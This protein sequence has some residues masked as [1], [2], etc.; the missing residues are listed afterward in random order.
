M[1][2]AHSIK[3]VFD[4][5]PHFRIDPVTRNITNRSGKVV[6]VQH[7][8]NSERFTFEIPQYVDGHDM[9]L[10]NNVEIHYINGNST[11]KNPGL[12]K[13]DDLTLDEANKIVYCSWL[14]SH[15]ATKL[16][17]PLSFMVRFECLTGDVI[18]YAW[19]TG[20]HSGVTVS[21][22]IYNTDCVLEDYVDVLE[23]WRIELEEA[24]VTMTG[25]EQTVVSTEDKGIN[26]VT[27]N[28]SNGTTGTFTVQNGSR[29]PTGS[30]IQSITRTDGTGAA[31]TTDTY[32]ITLTDGKTSTFQVYNG[33]NGLNGE[34]AGDMIASTYDPNNIAKDIFAYAD[35]IQ[36]N[37][38]YH[39][40]DTDMHVTVDEK[41]K[42][43]NKQD[44]LT[45]D[46]VPTADSDNPVTSGGV[47]TSLQ[48]IETTIGDIGA[49]LDSI[50]GE[51]V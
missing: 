43:G 34:G 24:G 12:Y 47:Y 40:D 39:A 21:H 17:G 35:K 1:A 50:N 16:I 26:E 51:V 3:D 27:M 11:Q 8:H 9:S 15:N 19:S 18:D 33:A 23:Q 49:I 46:T 14:I 20:V 44:A 4:T 37:L 32:T 25:I 13:V 36:G 41:S 48:N 31:G 38:N 10:C 30:S 6:L 2:H 7:D 28:F 29:G 5:D 22:G 45:F 42:W